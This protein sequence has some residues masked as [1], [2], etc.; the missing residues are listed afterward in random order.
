MH[1]QK[2]WTSKNQGQETERL[3]G[4]FARSLKEAA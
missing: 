2:F 1:Y 4:T 3:D